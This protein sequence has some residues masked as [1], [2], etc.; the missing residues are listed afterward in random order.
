MIG[1][2]Q[3]R[4]DWSVTSDVIGP[5]YNEVLTEHECVYDECVVD[6]DEETRLLFLREIAERDLYMTRVRTINTRLSYLNIIRTTCSSA[7]A[8]TKSLNSR[9]ARSLKRSAELQKQL[10]AVDKTSLAT[11]PLSRR[12]CAASSHLYAVFNMPSEAKICA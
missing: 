10:S 11:A 2:I 1:E 8:I 9:L 5:L 6:V 12:G 7:V 3:L 4:C